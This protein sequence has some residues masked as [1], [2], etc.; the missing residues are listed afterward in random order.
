[1]GFAIV[2]PFVGWLIDVKGL[3]WTFYMLA[4]LFTLCIFV[5]LI[6]IIRMVKKI[7]PEP[8]PANPPV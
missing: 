4:P 3:N 7:H 2:A 5:F 1:M 8:I 6:P